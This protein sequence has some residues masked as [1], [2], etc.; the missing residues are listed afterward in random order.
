MEALSRGLTNLRIIIQEETAE[1]GL[2]PFAIVRRR[3]I[4]GSYIRHAN[5][6][7]NCAM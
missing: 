2:T 1:M 4:A 3:Y 7:R 5:S 6:V